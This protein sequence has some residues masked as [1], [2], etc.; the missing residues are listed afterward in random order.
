MQRLDHSRRSVMVRH[1]RNDHQKSA[2]DSLDV[3]MKT[4]QKMMEPMDSKRLNKITGGTKYF[5]NTTLTPKHK[6]SAEFG[7]S[8]EPMRLNMCAETF[9]RVKLFRGDNDVEEVDGVVQMKGG[10][11]AP[12]PDGAAKRARMKSPCS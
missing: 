4:H 2:R 5:G 6:L 10:R 7:L 9:L 1:Y 3:V 12:D 8:H 11:S